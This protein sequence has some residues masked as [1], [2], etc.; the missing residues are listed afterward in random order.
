MFANSKGQLLS[1]HSYAVGCLALHLFDALRIPSKTTTTLGFDGIENFRRQIFLSGV[2]HDIGKID[3]AFQ[4]FLNNKSVSDFEPGNPGVHIKTKSEKDKFSF[5]QYPR[6][7]EVSWAI[8]KSAIDFNISLKTIEPDIAYTLYYHHENILR[9]C[10]WGSS[11]ILSRVHEQNGVDF[12]NTPDTII[13]Q[14]KIFVSEML[15]YS[16]QDL[17]L[18]EIFKNDLKNLEN[19]IITKEM[20]EQM[21]SHDTTPPLFLF[22]TVC[23]KDFKEPSLQNFEVDKESKRMLIRSLVVSA[24]RIISGLNKDDLNSVIEASSYKG[25]ITAED[26]QDLSLFTSIKKMVENFEQLNENS[27]I[28]AKRDKQQK[29]AADELS[30][31]AKP[32]VLF[33]PA[34][35]GKTKIFLQWCAQYK[36]KHDNPSSRLYVIAPRKTVCLGLYEELKKDYLPNASIEMIVGDVKKRWDKG[37]E[38]DLDFEQEYFKSSVVITTIDQITSIMMSHK[39]IDILLD[40]LNSYVVFDEFHEFFDLPG[41][42]LLFKSI[43]HLKSLVSPSKTLLVSATPN[44]YFVDNVLEIG[45]PQ[46]GV[47]NYFVDVETFN[48]ELYE[49]TLANYEVEK[50]DKGHCVSIDYPLEMPQQPGALV[51]FN[52]AKAAQKT[53]LDMCRSAQENIINFHSRFTPKDRQKNMDI[54]LK[55]WGKGAPKSQYVLRSGPIVQ[56]SL[57]ISSEFMLTELCG[58]EN[59]CQRLGRVNRFG[60]VNQVGK[61]STA[62]PSYIRSGAAGFGL[63]NVLNFLN[64]I[65]SKEQAQSW[66][67]FLMSKDLTGCIQLK[68]VYSWYREYHNQEQTQNAYASDFKATLLNSL[69]AFKNNDFKPYLFPQKSISKD[70]PIKLSSKGLR[71][72]SVFVLPIEFDEKS[73]TAKWL[74]IPSDTVQPSD[75]LSISKDEVKGVSSLYVNHSKYIGDLKSPFLTYPSKYSN[76]PEGKVSADARSITTPL[77]LS[78]PPTLEKYQVL[79]PGGLVYLRRG[80]VVF[81][82]V[83]YDLSTK[84]NVVFYDP[85]IVRPE[86]KGKKES[87]KQ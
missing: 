82:L 76:R 15:N 5:L 6:H 7:K 13:E 50:N 46:N 45:K 31:H 60:V 65:N 39:K 14:I 30:N 64:K 56:A 53:A 73:N 11:A 79:N 32:M 80:D 38:S 84:Q 24:D 86:K 51:V 57:N 49:I 66:I 72:S 67:R 35:C 87:K 12:S 20:Y 68:D 62:V 16:R 27:A 41:I 17:D 77:I 22:N 34:G 8:F 78:Y 81:G 74:Y 47:R 36:E 83:K 43:L 48:K 37:V 4:S 26:E 21:L 3:S 10:V 70:K 71:G 1:Q 58:A 9:D 59:W 40:I 69:K 61:Y 75:A 29:D 52:T 2:L 54:I 55:Q 85:I 19:S 23:T 28:G 18:S 44:Y 42:V 25:L 63:D 33:G